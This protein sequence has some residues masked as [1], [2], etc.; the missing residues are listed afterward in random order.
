MYTY[1]R[2]SQFINIHSHHK[3]KVDEWVL[4]NAYNSLTQLHIKQLGYCVS[5]GVHPW[6]C[7]ADGFDADMQK[8]ESL[9]SLTNVLALG[10]IGL[11]RACS[12]PLNIQMK[13]WD[14]QFNLAQQY[15]KPIII[16]SVRMYDEFVPYIKRSKVPLIFHRYN[17]NSQQTNR[18]L[19][20]NSYFS[21]GVGVF[22][23]SEKQ[24]DVFRMI[25]SERLFM[26]T[27][28]QNISVERV[29][30]KSALHLGI[31]II[32]LKRII[33]NNF[34]QAFNVK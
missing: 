11:D 2:S 14:A 16:H 12:V 20:D 7:K 29:Y 3:P 28:T 4:R 24:L 13:Y 8:I 9:L 34:A 32:V 15:N 33:F 6:H 1:P 31:D 23:M 25:P 21:F 19:N 5:V 22:N 17:G 26:E 27:D 10:E 18:L 30:Q